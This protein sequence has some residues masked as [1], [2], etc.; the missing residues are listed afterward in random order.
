MF[1]TLMVFCSL[2]VSIG[3]DGDLYQMMLWCPA[4]FLCIMKLDAHVCYSALGLF[5]CIKKNVLR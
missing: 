3:S 4:P 1:A 5:A 2:F